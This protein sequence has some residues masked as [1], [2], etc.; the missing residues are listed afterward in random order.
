MGSC[1][2]APEPFEGHN[3]AGADASTSLLGEKA[4]S[5]NAG[6]PARRAQ[7]RAPPQFK[8]VSSAAPTHD[9]PGASFIFCRCG[10]PG[11]LVALLPCNH[12]SL[13]MSCAQKELTCPTCKNNFQDSRPSFRAAKR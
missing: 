10:G 5:Y 13:C 6:A 7:K 3:A 2:S 11:S 12:A 4:S 8:T 1:L 9:A